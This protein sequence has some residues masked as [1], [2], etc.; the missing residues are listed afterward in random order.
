MRTSLPLLTCT[1][2]LA[3]TALSSAPAYAEERQA[4]SAITS[5]DAVTVY[6]TRSEQSTFDVPAMVSSVDAGAAGHALAGDIGD[7]LEHTASVEVD[8]G[9]RRTGQTISIRGFDDEAIITLID[10]RRQNFEAQHDGRF[11]LDPSLL[12]RVEIVKGASS[13]IYGGGGVGGV[14]AFETKDAADLLE[15][16]QTMGATTSFSYRSAN[17]EYAPILTGYGRSGNWDVLGSLTYRNSGDIEQGNGSELS[18]EDQILSG[19]FKTGYTFNDFHNVSF[20]YQAFSNNAEEPNNGTTAIDSSNPIVNKDTLDN[21]FSLKYAYENP[22]NTW[23][24][25]KLHLYYN[26]SEVEEE[27]ISGTN[28]GRVQTRELETLGFTLDNQTVWVDTPSRKHTLSYGVEYYTDEQTGTSTTTGT[29]AGVPDAE[30]TNYG[31]YIQDEIVVENQMGELLF[32]PAVRYDS[33]ES[34]DDVG[35]SQDENEFSPK[36]AMSYKPSE[37]Y[38]LFGSWARAFRAPHLTEI[39]PSGQH[40]P[41]VPGPFGFPAN[42]FIANP[43]LKP[44]TV[45]TIELGAGVDFTGIFGE[46]DRGKVKFAWHQSDGENFI[47]QVIN[48]PGGT[49]T[50]VNIENASIHGWE[51]DG[52]YAAGPLTAKAGLAYVAAKNDNTGADLSNSIP[53]TFTSDVSYNIESIDSIVGWRARFAKENNKVDSGDTVTDGYGVHDLYYRWAPDQKGLENLTVD[54]GVDNVMDKAYARRFSTL[55]EEGRSFVGRVSFKW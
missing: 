45:T 31:V 41:G 44:E 3:S 5:L 29:R 22:A 32:I 23:L 33:Y 38:V 17:N 39:Y 37:N 20:Q 53:L 16:G 7:L 27:D 28:A 1:A 14:V 18:A 12:K 55:L 43:N 50:N 19:L 2:L 24:K 26:I 6:A 52:E 46:S 15:P 48:I 8:G 49:T 11:F 30:A 35:N 42:N 21:Q 51:I 54:L 47:S 25:P 34:D 10:G 9:P 13:A 4:G 40:F 36:F